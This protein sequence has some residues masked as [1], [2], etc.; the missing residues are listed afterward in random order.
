MRLLLILNEA[1]KGSHDDIY[2]AL[3]DLISFG[4][5]ESYEV[6]SFLALQASCFKALVL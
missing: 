2:S 6:I 1:I 3:D 5:L 4:N